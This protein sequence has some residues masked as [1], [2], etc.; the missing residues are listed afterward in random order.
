MGAVP[1]SHLLP[2]PEVAV[3]EH[4]AARPARCMLSTGILPAP[5]GLTAL[6]TAA[7]STTPFPL[8]QLPAGASQEPGTTV[9]AVVMDVNKKDGIVD[10]SLQTALVQRAQAAAAAAAAGAEQQQPKKK[11]KH[12]KGA[13]APAA[14][15]AQQVAQL[16]EGQQVAACI[17]L[18]RGRGVDV[19]L[20][21]VLS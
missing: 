1:N 13:A 20:C 5:A 4:L 9:Q 6:P 11:Q 19:W 21:R 8:L 3:G 2:D 18:V 17:E 16:Q 15:A 12:K 7:P 10:L 14:G